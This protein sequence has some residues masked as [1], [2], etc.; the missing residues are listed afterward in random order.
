MLKAL[1]SPSPAKLAGRALYAHVSAAARR[2]VFYVEGEAPDTPEGRFEIYLLHLVL[3]LRRLK[4]DGPEAK[5]VSQALFDAFVRGLDDGL[6]EMGV[7][8]LSV[9]KKMRKLGEAIYGRIRAYDA[10]LA[11]DRPVEAVAALLTRTLYGEERRA[12]ARFLA[13]YVLQAAGDLDGQATLDLLEGRMA[14]L[15]PQ[16]VELAA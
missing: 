11:E 6:R 13:G 3:V 2:P 12:G 8:D 7:G 15:T 16:A 10:A 9:G 1:F 14:F 4:G 5:A